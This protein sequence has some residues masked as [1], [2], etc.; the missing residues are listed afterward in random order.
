MYT[1]LGL[2]AAAGAYFY[3]SRNTDE[4]HELKDKAKAEPGHLK[5]KSA[6]LADAAKERA[7]DVKQ[8]GKAKWDQVKACCISDQFKI[9]THDFFSDKW[10]GKAE[11]S[12]KGGKGRG[13]RAR[14]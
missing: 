14:C 2:V 6:E 10:Q 11:L 9:V 8:Q 12:G 5:S 3:F 4:V 13:K 1:T 7:E